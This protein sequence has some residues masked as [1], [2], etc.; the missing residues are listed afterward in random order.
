MER[1]PN[2]AIQSH[3]FK[4]FLYFSFDFD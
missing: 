4:Y 3:C 1:N 2:L